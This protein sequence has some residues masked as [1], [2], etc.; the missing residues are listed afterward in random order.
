MLYVLTEQELADLRGNPEKEIQ[1]RL[2]EHREE[3]KAAIVEF[4]NTCARAVREG[5]A[6]P[7]SDYDTALG[8]A[9]I[10]MMERLDLI[11][12]WK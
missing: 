1:K 6:N 8:N 11:G 7:I 12:L 2:V 9:A 10:R 5:R 3:V 4:G